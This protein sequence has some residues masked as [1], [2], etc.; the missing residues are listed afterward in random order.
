MSDGDVSSIELGEKGFSYK[1]IVMRQLQRCSDSLC[2]EFRGGYYNT[3]DGSDYINDSR[4]I[5]CSHIIVLSRLLLSKFDPQMS[6][7]F[8]QFNIDL[9]KIKDKFIGSTF[10]KET[11]ILGSDYYKSSQDKFLL[12]EYK[13]NKLDLHLRLFEELSLFLGRK[14][15]L[16]MVGG[17]F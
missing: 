11:V 17:T 14:K 8:K 1:E 15:F 6:K 12:E 4:E 2:V 3:V 13:Q 16:E 5:A 10:E 9:K 7:E